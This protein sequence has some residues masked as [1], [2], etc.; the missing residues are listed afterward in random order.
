MKVNLS[1]CGALH[2][3]TRIFLCVCL[4]LLLP[5]LSEMQLTG[6]S[7]L[8]LLLLP[9]LALAR[10]YLWRTRWLL[11]MLAL[12][13]PWT[14]PG[15]YVWPAHWSPTTQGLHVA[16]QQVRRC[17]LVLVALGAA[18]H[19]LDQQRRLQA[20]LGFLWPLARLGLPVERLAVRLALTLDF[21]EQAPPRRSWQQWLDAWQDELRRP[22]SP[23]TVDIELGRWSWCDAMLCGAALTGVVWCV[24]R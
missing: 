4:L 13:L 22:L 16:W 18:M 3:A 23:Q 19:G 1:G 7:L 20:F 14:T 2:P 11:L 5:F 17:V 10:R 21:L 12:V 9:V 15:V 24:G 8:A 6:L